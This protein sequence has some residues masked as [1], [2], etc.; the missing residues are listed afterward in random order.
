MTPTYKIVSRFRGDTQNPTGPKCQFRRYAVD[1]VLE[2]AKATGGSFKLHVGGRLFY[3]LGKLTPPGVDAKVDFDISRKRGGLEE[4]LTNDVEVNWTSE[5]P[6]DANAEGQ[7]IITLL[8]CFSKWGTEYKEIEKHDPRELISPTEGYTATADGEA[9]E[10]A[11]NEYL[12]V[13][14]VDFTPPPV[15][16]CPENL[17]SGKLLTRFVLMSDA[18]VGPT[19]HG[20]EYGWLDNIGRH[21][22]ALHAETPLDFVAQLGDNIDDGYPHNYQRDYAIYLEQI[23]K[24]TVCDPANPI[25][26]RAEGK[27]PHYELEGNHDYCPDLRYLRN[28]LWFTESEAGKVAFVGFFTSYGGYPLHHYDES[29][30]YESYR[31]YGVISEET[32]KFLDE[33]IR[34]AASQGAK[35]IVLLSHFGISQQLNAPVLPESG[36]GKLD[37]LCSEYGIRLF[38]SGH[39]HNC[40]FPH[41]MYKNVH[42]FDMATAYFYYAVVEIYENLCEV[43]I[44]SAKDQ[45]LFRTDRVSLK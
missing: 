36:L 16:T 29:G 20:E 1:I 38:F 33:S 32:E 13:E 45:S 7:K 23:K 17:D 37:H 44:Y 4:F 35:H 26:G 19:Y 34:E 9:A 6:I 11:E 2:N 31:S 28:S 10:V 3:Y 39:E 18:H 8:F 43:K 25:D 15:P 14:N 40:D 30:S 24:L 5:K 42:D 41:R 27:I 21:L 22:E 12:G